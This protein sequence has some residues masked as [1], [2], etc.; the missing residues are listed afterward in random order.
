MFTVKHIHLTGSEELYE[1][2]TVNFVSAEEIKTACQQST[3]PRN[4][5]S[6][7]VVNHP[8]GD[9]K[10]LYDGTVFAMNDKGATVSRWDLG[11][12]MVPLKYKADVLVDT[13]RS[14]RV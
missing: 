4:P 11:A 14:Q 8:N 1:A 6:H 2:A 3:E 12:S 5:K 10:C 9:V 13:P 7:V